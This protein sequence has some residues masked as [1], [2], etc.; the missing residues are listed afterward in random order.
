M[1][2]RSRITLAFGAA[3]IA[4]GLAFTPVAFG[5]GMSNDGMKKDSMANDKMKKDNM[6]NDKMKKDNMKK[7]SMKKDDMKK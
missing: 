3:T 2:T 5:Q 7:D 1:T 4:F 6:A